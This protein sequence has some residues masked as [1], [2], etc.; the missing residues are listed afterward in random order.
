ME[1]NIYLRIVDTNYDF[2][3]NIIPTEI[4]E[5]CDISNNKTLIWDTLED[6][7]LDL[8]IELDDDIAFSYFGITDCVDKII[9]YLISV[10]DC[11][12]V[13]RKQLT[14][15]VRDLNRMK[16]HILDNRNWITNGRHRKPYFKK[17]DRLVR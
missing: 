6:E 14:I 5:E 16:K 1:K 10:E 9:C 4:I 17:M 11:G 13:I 12:E 3:R 2:L 15:T 7:L 8:M